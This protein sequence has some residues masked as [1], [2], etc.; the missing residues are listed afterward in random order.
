MVIYLVFSSCAVLIVGMAAGSEQWWIQIG[1]VVKIVCVPKSAKWVSKLKM[2][3]GTQFFKKFSGLW[4]FRKPSGP[5]T[6]QRLGPFNHALV[7]ADEERCKFACNVCV[8]S[9]LRYTPCLEIEII[10][11]H[12]YVKAHTILHC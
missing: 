2:L 6:S 7:H 9:D 11:F 4:S 5:A 10:H 12:I 3:S 1:E 8:S